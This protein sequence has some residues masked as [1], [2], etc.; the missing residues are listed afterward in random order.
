MELLRR[1]LSAFRNEGL[2]STEVWIDAHVVNIPTMDDVNYQLDA[3]GCCEGKLQHPFTGFSVRSP[4]RSPHGKP[5][6]D[7]HLHTRVLLRE[8]LEPHY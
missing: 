3:T 7:S 5:V 6:G 4:S 2:C 1:G 8:L